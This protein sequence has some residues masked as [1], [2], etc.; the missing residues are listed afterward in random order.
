MRLGR[1][2]FQLSYWVLGTFSGAFAKLNFGRVSLSFECFPGGWGWLGWLGLGNFPEAPEEAR[3]K[4]FEA[5]K[6]G[7][8]ITLL[9]KNF[10]PQNQTGWWFQ[11]FFIFTPYLGKISNLTNIFRKGLK[12]PP[13]KRWVC[14][15][16]MIFRIQLGD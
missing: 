12:P 2:S 3:D 15:V 4:T 9:A 5:N 14:V 1:R 10:F 6:T 16:Q 13:S 11:I 7:R 8:M